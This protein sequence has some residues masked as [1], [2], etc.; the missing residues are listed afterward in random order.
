MEDATKL[1][2]EAAGMDKGSEAAATKYKEA[3]ME[4]KN[5]ALRYQEGG[6]PGDAGKA[7]M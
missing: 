3:G 5:V 4:Y 2:E 1:L 6:M 7:I